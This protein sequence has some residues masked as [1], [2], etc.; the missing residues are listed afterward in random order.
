MAMEMTAAR[1][2]A[3]FFGSSQIIWT[4]II[5]IV[6]IAL[7]A[8]Y[9]YGGIYADK[10][11][12]LSRLLK[13]MLVA[14]CLFLITPFL[15]HPLAGVIIDISRTYTTGTILL[16]ISS[17]LATISLFAFPIFLLGMVSPFVIRLLETDKQHLGSVA[18][19][20]FAVGTLGSILGTFLPILV[21]IPQFGVKKTVAGI[22]LL[23]I[24][25]SISGLKRKH[26]LAVTIPFF[27]FSMLPPFPFPQQ[28]Y[29]EDSIYQFIRVKEDGLGVRRLIF[30]DGLGVQSFYHPDTILSGEYYDAY[31]PLVES[32]DNV[33]ILGLAGGTIARGL[34]ALHGEHIQ[35]TGVE[36]DKKVVDVAKEFFELPESVNIEIAD[37]RAFIQQTDEK[38]DVIIIDAYSNEMYIPWTLTTKEFFLTLQ[39]RLNEGGVIALNINAISEESALLQVLQNTIASVF[40]FTEQIPLTHNGS[41]NYL[42]LAGDIKQGDLQKESSEELLHPVID[43]VNSSRKQFFFNDAQKIFT[44]DWAPVELFTDMMIFDFFKVKN[45]R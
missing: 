26:F 22:S 8:G 4:N 21:F 1:M 9:Y 14:G 16:L 19:I 37:A 13:P 45:R 41:I 29:A 36:I 27:A 23:L 18:G 39:S 32:G 7:S 11:P 35:I 34:D 3:P 25:L 15:I 5:G 6:L 28:L 30:N 20:V 42:L 33:L 44:D 2:M 31:L 12:E 17:F 24:L 43:I 10:H 38:Y 40:S